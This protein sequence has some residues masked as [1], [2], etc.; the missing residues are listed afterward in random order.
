MKMS[1]IDQVYDTMTVTDHIAFLIMKSDFRPNF[2][3][4]FTRQKFHLLASH[5][6]EEELASSIRCS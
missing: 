2:L 5:K 6:K 1:I 4:S 3:K